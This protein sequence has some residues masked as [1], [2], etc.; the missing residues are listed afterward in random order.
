MAIE[1]NEFK[2]PITP[3]EAR[4]FIQNQTDSFGVFY[5]MDRSAELIAI[6]SLEMR[7]IEAMAMK[8][9]GIASLRLGDKNSMIGTLH[10]LGVPESVFYPVDKSGRQAKTA[11]LNVDVE[12]A[13]LNNPILSPVVKQTTLLYQKFKK[14]QNTTNKL[15]KRIQ[16]LP[17]SVVLAKNGHRMLLAH[18]EWDVLSTSRIQARNPNVQQIDRV[19]PEVIYSGAS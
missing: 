1:I 8:T 18:P 10:S 5:D 2:L 11:S 6:F 7:K 16:T 17:Q 3:R 15:T 13:I 19:T 4:D 9:S 14:F 12:N